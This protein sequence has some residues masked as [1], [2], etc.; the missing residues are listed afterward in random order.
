MNS[1]CT[2]ETLHALNLE[3]IHTSLQRRFCARYHHPPDLDGYILVVTWI[4]KPPG[5][6]GPRV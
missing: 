4:A 6:N 2:P 1:D 3:F 5:G